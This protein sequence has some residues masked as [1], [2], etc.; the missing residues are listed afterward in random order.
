[1]A[2]FDQN[3]ASMIESL[4]R[5]GTIDA[6]YRTPAQQ[7]IAFLKAIQR[8]RPLFATAEGS[9]LPVLDVTPQYR[10]NVSREIGGNQIIDW[11]LR[12]AGQVYPFPAGGKPIR[13][14]YNDPV[15]LTLRYAKDS[16]YVPVAKT[17]DPD[18]QIGDRRITYSYKT[19]W[20]LFALLVQR[21]AAP[22][23]F[24]NPLAPI[25]NTVKLTFANAPGASAVGA[26][27]PADTTV[28]VSITLQ[29]PAAKEGAAKNGVTIS[30]FP[31]SAP[32][33]P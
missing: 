14:H 16:P 20:S 6:N 11:D 15:T 17:P 22:V 7:A 25:P 27:K 13:W 29:S 12:I 10:T 32:V 33:M 28:Y 23:D 30:P 8:I 3:G 4:D 24:D 2:L 21:A 31:V 5:L 18:V 19:G 1:M 26:S 9:T